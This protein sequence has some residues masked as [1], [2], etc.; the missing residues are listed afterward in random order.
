M[1]VCL[2]LG[3]EDVY[4]PDI[5]DRLQAAVDRTV[6]E[7][8]AVEF[9]L[10]YEGRFFYYCLLAVLRA[11]T[12]NPQAV[13]IT[14]AYRKNYYDSRIKGNEGSALHSIVDKIMAYDIK[15]NTISYTVFQRK[16]WQWLIHQSTHLIMCVYEKLRETENQALGCVRAK[17]EADALTVIDITSPETERAIM[18]S[19]SLLTEQEQTAFHKTNEGCT[20]KEIGKILGL[21]GE[22]TRHILRHGCRTIMDHLKRN[23]YQIQKE[24]REQKPR[25][26]GVFSLGEPTYEALVQF[27]SMIQFLASMYR[28]K[29]F[30]VEHRLARSGYMYPLMRQNSSYH[31]I[32]ITAVTDEGLLTQNDCGTEHMVEFFCPPCNAVKCVNSADFRNSDGPLAVISDIM[33]NCDFCICDLSATLHAEVIENYSRLPAGPVLFNIGEASDKGQYLLSNP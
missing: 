27:D 5:E 31:S 17:A 21:S 29:H 1:A 28:V 25:I 19:T 3:H 12:R 24:K 33:E 8:E 22:R 16:M 4:D 14:V 9:L 23:C 20:L 10:N 13:T 11:R 2:F 6:A 30:W 15:T 7:N 32:H 26:C 18:D